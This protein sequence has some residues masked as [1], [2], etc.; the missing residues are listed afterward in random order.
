MFVN[1]KN[2]QYGV[3]IDIFPID[4]LGNSEKE[5]KKLLHKSLFKRSL[6]TA[7]N[8]KKYFKSKTRKWYVEP[9]RWI[10]YIFSRC[11]NTNKLIK[12][13]ER[14]YKK[15]SFEDCEKVGVYCGCYGDKEIM[16]SSIFENFIDV[17]FEKELFTVMED[18]D[19]FLINLYGDYM[20]LPPP[21]KRITHHTFKAYK[22]I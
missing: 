6:L 13:I 9:V 10:F 20:Q 19:K 3:Y 22:K 7:A 17:E 11:V 16:D 8:W 12:N 15:F 5:A 2:A 18:Y 4:G 14:I 1:R 21:D